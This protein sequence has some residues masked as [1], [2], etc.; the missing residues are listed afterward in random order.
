MTAW[1]PPRIYV[2]G[3]AEG[4]SARR[5]SQPSGTLKRA[6]VACASS[7]LFIACSPARTSGTTSWKA[8]S[9]DGQVSWHMLRIYLKHFRGQRSAIMQFMRSRRGYGGGGLGSADFG[10]GSERRERRAALDDARGSLTARRRGGVTHRGSVRRPVAARQAGARHRRPWRRHLSR[11]AGRHGGDEPV[12]VRRSGGR[13]RRP[14]RRRVW[15]AW[16]QERFPMP[17][18][19]VTSELEG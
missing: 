9:P 17:T 4:W 7:A 5:R 16:F 15:Q 13:N 6:L 2:A 3:Q 12:P 10:V 14:A 11:R 18:E 19:P 1:D 8:P